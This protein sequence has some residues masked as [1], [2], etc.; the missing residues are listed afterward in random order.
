MSNGSVLVTGGAGFIGSAIA[1]RLLEN[2][3]DIVIVD[4][5]YT[6]K[7][8]N[9]PAE[10]RLVE[11]DLAEEETVER[12]DGDAIETVFH[13]AGQSSGEKSFDDPEYDFRSHA[14][15]TFNLLQWCDA[16]DISRVL[17]ASSMSVYGEP[18]YLPVDES[19]PVSPKTYYAAG[20]L[21]GEA[22]VK[23]FGNMGN[24]TTIFRLFSVYGPGQNLENMKQGMASIYL[25]F[26][27]DGDELVIKGST[28]RFRDFVFIDDVVDVWM[29]TK[30]APETYGKVYN[31]GRGRRIE[32]AELVE[33]IFDCYGVSDY[34]TKVTDGTPGDQFGI[35]GDASKLEDD[36]GWEA[37]TSLRDGIQAM[38]DAGTGG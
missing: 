31:L 30:D 33:T 17:Y 12:L 28:D 21:S 7:R 18:E 25:S 11:G 6:G 10:A 34:P 36:I 5:L 37:T 1:K 19:H 24:E 22:Y 15:G 23:Q 35:Y 26:V 32:V 16:E 8:A 3:E 13:L 9:V 14:L 29:A 2:G 38:V 4:N 20:K 27:M